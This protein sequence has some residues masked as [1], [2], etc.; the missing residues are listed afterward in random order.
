[1]NKRLRSFLLGKIKTVYRIESHSA[2]IE[3][4]IDD[5]NFLTGSSICL[6]IGC[7][8]TTSLMGKL[9]KKYNST[10]Y[11]LDIDEDKINK[12]KAREG[13]KV[14]NVKFLIGDSLDTLKE[15]IENHKRVDFA[16]LDSSASAI[17]TFKEFKIIEPYLAPN[18]R[19]I[20]DNAAIPEKKFLLSP[21][22]K[23]KILIPYLL[24]SDTW[25]VTSLARSGDSMVS[26]IRH[27]DGGHADIAYE[28]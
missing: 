6:E 16:F 23:G 14:S 27:M 18:A 10:I 7:G 17:Q 15:I 19:I 25:K 8:E 24:S 4:I 2:C 21:V 9:G 28:L 1:M 11:S 3:R 5:K 20:I 13:D 26:A 22:R 12:L